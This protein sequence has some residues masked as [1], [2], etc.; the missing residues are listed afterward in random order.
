[1]GKSLSLGLP[2]QTVRR[3][4]QWMSSGYIL[5]AEEEGVEML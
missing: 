3:R 1:M 4:L 2:Q 5:R